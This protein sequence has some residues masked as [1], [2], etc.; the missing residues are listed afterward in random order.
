MLALSVSV[1]EDFLHGSVGGGEGE[2][3]FLGLY[4]W[5]CGVNAMEM[6]VKGYLSIAEGGRLSLS[7]YSI[8]KR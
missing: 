4:I 5:L 8:F 2:G 3:E 6:P 7:F 1:S